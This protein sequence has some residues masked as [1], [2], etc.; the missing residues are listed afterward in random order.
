MTVLCMLLSVIGTKAFQAHRGARV[1]FTLK[2]TEAMYGQAGPVRTLDYTIAVKSDGSMSEVRSM[3]TPDGRLVE[4]KT[5]TDLAAKKKFLWDG[6][7]ESISTMHLPEQR[8]K[9]LGSKR[10]TCTDDASA[11]SGEMLGYKVVRVVKDWKAHKPATTEAWLAP[12]LDCYPLKEIVRVSPCEPGGNCD[13][14]LM[15]ATTREVTSVVPGEPSEA[16]FLIRPDA[17]ERSPVEVMA[18]FQRRYP[19]VAKGRDMRTSKGTA[20]QEEV[21]RA[22]QIKK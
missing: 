3:V 15:L 21:Y 1:P 20:H 7:T 10:G 11:E 5:V 14:T 2:M 22:G 18:E 12:A 19:Q 8:V 4:Q 13:G 6:L 17:V 9:A 16:H